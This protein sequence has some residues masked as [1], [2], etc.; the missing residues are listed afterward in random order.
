MERRE[1]K[2]SSLYGDYKLFLNE[3]RFKVVRVDFS[4]ASIL[5]F[6]IDVPLSSESIWFGTEMTRVELDDKVE[7]EEVLRLL[8]LPPGQY[9]SSR[10][11]LK[12]FMIHNNIDG[13]GWTFQIVLLNLEGFKDS[14]Q[15]LVMCV[16]IQL[17]RNK[18]IGVKSNQ[19]KFIIFINNG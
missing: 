9:L 3:D 13:I 15:F 14:K 6:R 16:I 8:C 1:K 12:V 11:I 18:S 5:P 2:N 19:M 4:I 17:C 7:L 10:E